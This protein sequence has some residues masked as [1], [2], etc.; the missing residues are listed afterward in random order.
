MGL[1]LVCEPGAGL[2]PLH[3]LIYLNCK[4]FGKS[5]WFV[6]VTGAV[7][8]LVLF[9]GKMRIP[10]GGNEVAAGRSGKSLPGPFW[11]GQKR[12][13]ILPT[14]SL[15]PLF[16]ETY[17]EAKVNQTYPNLHQ[18]WRINYVSGMQARHKQACL[19][20]PLH[21]PE[22]LSWWSLRETSHRLSWVA[23]FYCSLKCRARKKTLERP[24]LC[25]MT[26]SVL[27]LKLNLK[28]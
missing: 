16:I 23:G 24:H 10:H 15:C 22:K 9:L 13:Q 17:L 4:Q 14:G 27:Y 20:S 19:F 11:G 28:D 2:H 21:S 5:G 1:A 3:S 6:M 8:A 7:S 26:S 25:A 18:V 12:L